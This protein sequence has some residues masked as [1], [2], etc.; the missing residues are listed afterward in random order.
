MKLSRERK[1]YAGMLLLG[2][3][4]LG[5]DRFIIGPPAT[6]GADEYSPATGEPAPAAVPAASSEAQG[7]PV[8]AEVISVGQRLR[9]FEGPDAE[10]ADLFQVPRAWRPEAPVVVRAA[11]PSGPSPSE[12]F[13]RRK[14]NGVLVEATGLGR[15]Q[16]IVDGQAILLGHSLDGF[17]LIDVTHKTAVFEG[18]GRQVVLQVVQPAEKGPVAGVD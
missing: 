4:A 13:K 11:Q 1:A 8:S 6:A 3:L 10:L 18:H 5:T 7:T 9:Q 2:L 12:L 15:R 14:L 16:A 17:R